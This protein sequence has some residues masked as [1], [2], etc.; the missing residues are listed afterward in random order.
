MSHHLAERL[1]EEEAKNKELEIY[2]EKLEKKLSENNRNDEA[3]SR[4]ARRRNRES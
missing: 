4:L 1:L 2:V 3:G